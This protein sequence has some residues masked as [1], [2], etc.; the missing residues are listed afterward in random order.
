MTRFATDTV[1]LFIEEMW[2]KRRLELVDEL[3][4]LAYR[5]DRV[6]VG[7]DFE[8]RNIARF[9]SAFPDFSATILELIA[10]GDGVAVLFE[11]A[12]TQRDVFAGIDPTGRMVRM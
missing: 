6:A 4:D 9:W 11:V 3:V 8:R 2:G 10:D 7:R 12:G 1:T 5:A